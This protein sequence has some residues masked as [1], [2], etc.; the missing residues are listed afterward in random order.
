MILNIRLCVFTV[1]YDGFDVQ[2][3]LYTMSL[4]A[5]GHHGLLFLE[6]GCLAPHKFIAMSIKLEINVTAVIVQL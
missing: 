4:R 6:A 5:C 1:L 2:I 3:S